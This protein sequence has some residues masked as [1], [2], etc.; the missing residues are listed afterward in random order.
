VIFVTQSQDLLLSITRKGYQ[1]NVVVNIRKIP[2]CIWMVDT[3]EWLVPMNE[4][5]VQLLYELFGPEH[6]HFET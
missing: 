6:V 3:L 2:G 4:R 1:A 5:T